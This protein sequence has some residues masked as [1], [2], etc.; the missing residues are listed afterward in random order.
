MKQASKELDI[1]IQKIG[2]NDG[3]TKTDDTDGD[4]HDIISKAKEYIA[5][6]PNKTFKSE[7]ETALNKND[8]N[9]LKDMFG[10]RIAFGT[11]GLRA[12]MKGGY[13]Y[14]NDLIVIQTSQG[15]LK[16][17]ENNISD[18]K[19][20][21]IIVGYDGRYNSKKW[22]ETTLKVFLS[23]KWKIYWFNRYAS[24]PMIPY[25]MLLKKLKCAL[26]IVVTASHN[27]KEYNGY[28][29]YWEN[30]AQIIP[31]NDVGIAKAILN[32]LK[33]WENYDKYNIYDDKYKNISM[34]V[35]DYVI[36]SYFND[37]KQYCYN[38]NDN[39]NSDINNKLIVTYTAM[40]GVGGYYID[41]AYESFKLPKYIKVKEQYDPDPEFKTVAFP[42]PEGI[43][44]YILK[45]F[46]IIY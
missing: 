44:R 27:P 17:A 11:A 36:N 35:T 30:G 1:L 12:K 13:K 46:M 33:P 9:I 20:K 21:G 19:N 2:G 18:C 24:T 22:C 38:V 8:V 6:E 42:N 41:K 23:Q 14:M 3:E 37:I 29:V 25:G 40:H 31:P 34:D 16:Y 28:K 43:T 7:V 26:G 5:W 10:K 32:N 4:L 39:Q 15:L 45:L